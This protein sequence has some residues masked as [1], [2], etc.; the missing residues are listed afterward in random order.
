MGLAVGRADAGDGAWP[1]AGLTQR[2]FGP[3]CQRG[4]VSRADAGGV[5]LAG[6]G[7]RAAPDAGGGALAVRSGPSAGLTPAAEA[8]PSAR[9][10]R[11]EA[12]GGSQATA[13][14]GSAA[15]ATAALGWAVYGTA[16][17][18]VALYVVVRAD[19]CSHTRFE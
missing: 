6:G 18:F 19:Q 13:A 8:W 14:Q 10:S 9:G 1:L 3:G 4:T 2:L 17:L 15:Q 11:L 5:V 12:G 7:G 16:A